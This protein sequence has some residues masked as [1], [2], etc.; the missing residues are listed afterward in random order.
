MST[1]M[2]RLQISL[3]KRQLQFL[4]E[5]ARRDGISAAEVIRRLLEREEQTQVVTQADI[6]AALSFAGIVAD[7]GP[8]INGLPVSENVDL[9]LSE[10]ALAHRVPP[11][12]EKS[13]KRRT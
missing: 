11:R 4:R 5:R 13:R 8:L 6:D 2:H 1:S 3:P 10:L 7:E 12:A 9:Y